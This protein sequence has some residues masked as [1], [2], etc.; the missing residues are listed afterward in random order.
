MREDKQS[1]RRLQTSYITTIVSITLVLLLL[2]IMG[3]LIINARKISVHV[4]ENIG[5]SIILHENVKEADILRMQKGFE[6]QS[7]VRSTRYISKEQAAKELQEDLGEDFVQFI[8]HN[9]LPVSIEIKLTAEYANNDS[10]KAIE[11]RLKK[12]DQI[13]EVWYQ[14]N[15]IALVNDNIHKISLIIL[16]FALVL[17]FISLVLINN[18]IHL[19][20]YSKRFLIK[21]MELVGATKQFILAPFIRTGVFHGIISGLIAIILLSGIIYVG[22]NQFPELHIFDNF[23][24][25][26]ILYV[27]VIILGVIISLFSTLFAVNKYLKI[28]TDKLYF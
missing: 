27:F 19:A 28:N 23:T 14:K 24:A 21:T 2:G 3:F 16:G 18:T 20:I 15:L 22:N 13:K 8:G 11:N 1:V 5:I 9:P 6:T 12:S 25:I 17:F 10:I 7:Y 26:S 4:K